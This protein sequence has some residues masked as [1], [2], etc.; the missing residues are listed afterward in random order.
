MNYNQENKIENHEFTVVN[1]EMNHQKSLEIYTQLQIAPNKYLFIT[2]RKRTTLQM[3]N[4]GR[5]HGN[6]NKYHGNGANWNLAP[7]DKTY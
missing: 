5:H 7:A 2:K 4:P 6:P 3:E 1:T